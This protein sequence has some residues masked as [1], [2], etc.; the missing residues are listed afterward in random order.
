MSDKKQVNF[1]LYEDKKE[2][3]HKCIKIL[4]DPA[5]FL[6]KSILNITKILILTFLHERK[7]FA[8][9]SLLK[10]KNKLVDSQNVCYES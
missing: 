2:T 3:V 1:P 7:R 4:A 9:K 8:I 10:R 6:Q 5:F